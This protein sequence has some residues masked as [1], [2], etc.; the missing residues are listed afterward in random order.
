MGLKHQSELYFSSLIPFSSCNHT[1]IFPLHIEQ[2]PP[3]PPQQDSP[4]PRMPCKHNLWQPTPRLSGT[5]WLE[6]LFCSKQPTFPFLIL[7]FA[8]SE[9]TFPPFVEPS[10]YDEPPILGPSK[11]S[12]PH[13]DP[14][15][16]EPEPEVATT[17]SM[18][19]PF[20]KSHFTF[21]TLLNFSSPLLWP[22]PAR[23]AT[24]VSIIIINNTPIGYP[25]PSTPTPEIPLIAPKSPTTSSPQSHDEA[26]QEFTELRPNLIIP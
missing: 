23:P 19:E 22:Y 3:N 26:W 5:Q 25:P 1:D 16:C 17:K 10:Q 12:E 11:A 13:E 2:N 15:T 14:L 8:S 4:V 21:F 7:N 20:G 24:P 6:D 9:L 18:E